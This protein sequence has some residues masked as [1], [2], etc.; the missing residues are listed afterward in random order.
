MKRLVSFLFVSMVSVSCASG[1]HAATDTNATQV[2]P[3]TNTSTATT[4]TPV[5]ILHTNDMHGRMDAE[6][7]RV[8]GL[9]KVKTI[10]DAENPTLM[11]DSGDAFQ[12]LPLSNMTK[13]DDMAKAMNAVGYD[14]MTV[15]NHEFDFGFDTAVGYK[16][17]LNFPI[18]SSNI[19]KDGKNVFD[20]STIINKDGRRFGIV[21]VTTPETKTKTHPNNVA[22]VTFLDPV[23]SVTKEMMRIQPNVDVF[24]I[25]SH[26][27]I[28]PSTQEN[29]RGDY[30]TKQI[31]A[32]KA[33]NRSIV[34]LDGHSHSVIE[35]GQLIQ[36]A[37]L[38]QTGTVL[39]NIGKVTFDLNGQTATNLKASM[40]KEAD[41]KA[42]AQDATVKAIVDQ[43]KDKYTK[44]TS[45]VVF[46]NDVL[47]NG[48]RD[49]VRTGETNLG[50]A[51]TDAMLA[52]SQNGF[53]TPGD[54]AV[55][56]GGG[57][58][59]SIDANKDVT[60]GDIIKVLPFGN[61][62]T[63]IDVTG[64]NVYKMFEHSLSAPTET[65]DD[66]TKLTAS[67]GLLH[68]SD[69]IKVHYDLSKPSGERVFYIEI[70]DKK[71]KRFVALDK[72]KTYHMVT[73][74]FTAVGGDGYTMLGGKR[75][76]G[77]SLDAVFRQFLKSVDLS[78]YANS[79][80][81]RLL[82]GDA[83]KFEMPSTE[84]TTEP[85]VEE[86]STNEETN[87]TEDNQ[88]T[89]ETNTDDEIT[90]EEVTA[91]EPVSSTDQ[92][93]NVTPVSTHVAKAET[94]EKSVESKH[95]NVVTMTSSEKE[96]PSTGEHS[97]P[98]VAIIPLGLG[99]YLL[100]RKSA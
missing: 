5:K 74:D 92:S 19:V 93:I 28:D 76:E 96:L 29:W 95:N 7:G 47:L 61:T 82:A 40:I 64:E 30:L 73:N 62:I 15:G 13:G 90:S 97:H 100:R 42:I 25:L 83:S 55:T 56:N 23:E 34:V 81:T 21:G 38:T 11:L 20:G 71:L 72:S 48:E 91:T 6:D 51:I 94:K 45:E 49:Y 2:Q 79:E 87:T 12:G 69:S 89:E 52:Y 54:F 66:V 57:I 99:L 85:E 68:V 3:T 41:T 16:S 39:A 17:K 8:I 35:N 67:G 78:K 50:N 65:K 53:D 27:G 1:V 75:Q 18:I 63:Q 33:F 86:G 32:N 77:P 36:N 9:A 59:A 43:A 10:K 98:E 44:A 70:Y 58:R 4:S 84:D 37:L 22:G 31:A 60:I 26:L 14:A 24:I 46:H 88:V 80:A